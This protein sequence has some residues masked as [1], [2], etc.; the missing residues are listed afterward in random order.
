MGKEKGYGLYY[1]LDA[2]KN[3]GSDL[4][5]PKPVVPAYSAMTLLI[6]GHKS[7]GPL[8]G[9][10]GNSVG[11]VFERDGDVIAAVWD[12]QRTDAPLDLPVG[13]A[14]VEVFDWMGR[15]LDGEVSNGVA[16]LKLGPE[17][18]YVRG[19]PAD[20][21][22][23]ANERRVSVQTPAIDVL[24]GDTAVVNGR[25]RLGK[26]ERAAD[27]SLGLDTAGIVKDAV[28]ASISA[29]G[30]FRVPVAVPASAVPGTYATKLVLLRN[31]KV[32]GLSGVA[33]AVKPI[34]DL[35][36]IA[37][38]FDQGRA[39]VSVR[40][41]NK[42]RKRTTA[43][44]KLSLD[45]TAASPTLTDVALEPGGTA[46][47]FLPVSPLNPVPTKRYR[48]ALEASAAGFAPT[49]ATAPVDF[50]AASRLNAAP[51]TDGDLADWAAIA[52]ARLQGRENIVRSPVYYTGDLAAA[53]RFGW[54][55]RA[56]YFA[57]EVESSTHT[58][59]YH[60][61]DIWRGD[62]IQMGINLTPSGAATK[63]GNMLADQGSLAY[64]ELS[65][66]LTSDGPTAVRSITF[67]P[68]RLPTG[69]IAATDL[70]LAITRRGGKTIYEAALPWSQLGVSSTPPPS[71]SLGIAA[72]VNKIYA[73]TQS[74]PC[75]LGL[76]D[77]IASSKDPD[78]FGTLLLTR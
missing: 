35:S 32:V 38:A 30:D 77:G 27:F 49:N 44:L 17:P 28:A 56:L 45:D 24:A 31:A 40:I 55:D 46:T 75:A 58:Q 34:I 33:L 22:G 3:W 47:Q 5:S 16:H 4:V 43:H 26:G 67:D 65:L 29:S 78:R 66:A 19:L 68:A 7:N 64:T 6:D 25:V 52:P 8:D 74:D 10:A 39:G 42:S 21:Y 14:P 60:G 70:P 37:A 57:C 41:A 51:T 62:C 18:V 50:L 12:S 15:K 13:D 76:F 2:N 59:P 20:L 9:M 11:Y 72:T 36:Q 73:P 61:A 63:T 53:F 54:D 71:G 69:A 48:A 1:N 23:T